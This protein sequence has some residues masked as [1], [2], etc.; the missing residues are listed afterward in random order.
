[1]NIIF[2]LVLLVA[3]VYIIMLYNGLVSL[4]TM[5]QKPGPIS[6]CC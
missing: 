1:M 5:S 2:W 3:V 6:M 4:K